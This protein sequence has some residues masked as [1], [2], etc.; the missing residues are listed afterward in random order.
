MATWEPM[1][2]AVPVIRID[3]ARLCPLLTKGYT[4]EIVVDPCAEQDQQQ[5]VPSKAA[6]QQNA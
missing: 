5:E 3:I 4:A 2:P 6:N 1:K